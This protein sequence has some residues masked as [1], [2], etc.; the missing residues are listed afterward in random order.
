VVVAVVVLV[1][2]C[3]STTINQ[4]INQSIKKCVGGGCELFV[5][6]GKGH[7]EISEGED[8]QIMVPARR[9]NTYVRVMSK[10]EYKDSNSLTCL[11]RG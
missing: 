2:S 3:S 9:Y 1:E 6:D 7:I 11:I 5:V 4:P 10:T 8:H